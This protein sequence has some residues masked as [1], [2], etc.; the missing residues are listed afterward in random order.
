MEF[1]RYVHDWFYKDFDSLDEE[2]RQKR[3]DSWRHSDNVR[4]WASFYNMFDDFIADLAIAHDLFEDT[5]CNAEKMRSDRVS[6][7]NLIEGIEALTRKEGEEYFD[8]IRRCKEFS[9]KTRQV[10][11]FDILDH[12]ALYKTLKP[13]LAKRYLKALEILLAE[14][15][16]EI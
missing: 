9:E 13:S 15:T 3:V 12:L 14:D 6:D 5:D 7:E 16:K 4:A 1:T 10:K 11:I 2:T 8:Y